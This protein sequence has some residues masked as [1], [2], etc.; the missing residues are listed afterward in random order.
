MNCAIL[1]TLYK[2]FNPYYLCNAVILG[3]G[4]VVVGGGVCFVGGG[5]GGVFS[6]IFYGMRLW[7]ERELL[8]KYNIG[9]HTQY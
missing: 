2:S 3:G 1:A 7:C 5:G 4:F 9:F 6:F 8:C